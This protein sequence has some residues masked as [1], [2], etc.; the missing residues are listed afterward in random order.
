METRAPWNPNLCLGCATLDWNELSEPST[1]ADAGT[2]VRPTELDHFLDMEGP[3]VVD[4]YN[5]VEQANQAIAETTA[6]EKAAAQT[7]ASAEPLQP[8]PGRE[9]SRSGM[10]S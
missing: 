1:Q 6:H 4:V 2:E 7:T 10:P 3:S 8:A 5:A 9:R